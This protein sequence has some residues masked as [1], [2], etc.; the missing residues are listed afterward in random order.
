MK[1]Y[2]RILTLI[3]L[4][5]IIALLEVFT[6]TDYKIIMCISIILVFLIL[7]T[8]IFESNTPKTLN[9]IIMIST[10]II[11]PLFI[12]WDLKLYE[13]LPGIAGSLL[14]LLTLMIM[15]FLSIFTMVK[16]N[17]VEIEYLG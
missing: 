3:S 13:L 14:T 1:H 10:F 16:L 5:L 12:A 6:D 11:L 7:F 15:G 17:Y 4:F 2:L 9:I 8:Y